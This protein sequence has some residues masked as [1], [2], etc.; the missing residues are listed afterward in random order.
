M[1]AREPSQTHDLRLQNRHTVFAALRRLGHAARIEIGAE[2][3]LSPATVTSITADLIAEDL[4]EEI[5]EQVLVRSKADRGRPRILL[6]IRPD[7]FLVA[8]ANIGATRIIVTLVDFEGQ[9][10]VH[11]VVPRPPRPGSAEEIADQLRRALDAAFDL[12]RRPV[13]ALDAL[14]VGIAGFIDPRAGLVHWSPC[15]TESGVT[16]GTHLTAAFKC[17]VFLDNDANL[18]ALAEQRFGYGQG[19]PDFLVVTIEEGIGLGI[20]ING[21]VHHGAGGMGGEF[22]HMTMVPDG[23]PC[24]CGGRGCLEAHV[25]DY[26]LLRE[27]EDVLGPDWAGGAPRMEALLA[28]AEAGVAGAVDILDRAGRMFAVALSSLAKILDPSLII[29]AG[30]N[31]QHDYLYGARSLDRMQCHTLIRD[32]APPMVRVHQWGDRFWALGAATV[33]VEGLSARIL[34]DPDDPDLKRRRVPDAG[35]A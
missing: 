29:F 1:P 2:T 22:G 20:V 28:A 15:L 31:L 3:G 33:A 5:E 25:A 26:A 23:A 6:R 18:A 19:I 14:G 27:A 12:A 13:A 8:G 34:A 10:I 7:R 21:A 30:D 17:P 16:F 11:H 4:I 32:R 9:E 24:R 35:G